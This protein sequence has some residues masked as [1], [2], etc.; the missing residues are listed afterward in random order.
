MI[1][2][3]KII[4]GLVGK[5]ASGKGSVAEYLEKKYNANTYSFSTILRDILKRL[6]Y[7]ISRTN[8]RTISTVLRKNFGEDLLAKVIAEDVKKDN[9][10]LIV[11]DGIRRIADIK[12]LNE[13]DGFILIKITA[14]LKTRYKRLI[15][16]TENKGDSQKTYENFLDDEQKETETLIPVVM[17]QAKKELTNNND[18]KD[19]YNQIDNILNL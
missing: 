12:F 19:L 10:K 18:F 11:V 9:N 15:E 4:I 5:I 8:M 17:K 2:D 6:H 16:R 1:K 7:E 13:M 3:K 14:N